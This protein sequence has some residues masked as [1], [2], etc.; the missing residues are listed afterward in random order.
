MSTIEIPKEARAAA[1]ASMQRYFEENMTEP[2][3]DLP[4]GLLLNFFVEEI[5]PV[6]YNQAIHDAQAR[7]QQRAAD[8]DGELYADAFQYWARIDAK[9][10]NRR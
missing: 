5:G 2:I 3:G 8:L 10:K 1:I 4:A 6:L 7:I 9:Q